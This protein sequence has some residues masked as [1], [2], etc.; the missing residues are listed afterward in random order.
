MEYEW[1]L[2]LDF[3]HM[4]DCELEEW[5]ELYNESEAIADEYGSYDFA[6]IGEEGCQ[7]NGYGQCS[8]EEE[9]DE[10]REKLANF[11]SDREFECEIGYGVLAGGD[12]V[13]FSKYKYVGNGKDVK[14]EKLKIWN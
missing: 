9:F 5:E 8:S 7:I 3:F 12:Y 10:F 6:E 4:E 13:P 2:M 14:V 1:Y 11:L